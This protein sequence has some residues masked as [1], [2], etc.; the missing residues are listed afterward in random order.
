MQH[1]RNRNE[2]RFVFIWQC[3]L[4]ASQGDPHARFEGMLETCFTVLWRLSG[5]SGGCL[6]VTGQRASFKMLSHP[7]QGGDGDHIH[8]SDQQV[9]PI[10]LMDKMFIYLISI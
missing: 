3:T 4:A 7:E 10:I 5:L 1:F 2:R 6:D 9:V 8:K